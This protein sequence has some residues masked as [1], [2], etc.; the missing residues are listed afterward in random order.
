MRFLVVVDIPLIFIV[1]VLFGLFIPGGKCCWETI[2]CFSRLL[3]RNLSL[4]VNMSLSVLSFFR[5]FILT[6]EGG[7]C[8]SPSGTVGS[9]VN[10]YAEAG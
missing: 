7:S 1:A 10:R 5:R 6:G 3:L 4:G 9:L 2:L 8:R